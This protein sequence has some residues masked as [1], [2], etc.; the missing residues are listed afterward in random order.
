MIKHHKL[1]VKKT[2]S[3]VLLLCFKIL[4]YIPKQSHTQDKE[5]YGRGRGRGQQRTDYR[6]KDAQYS[7]Q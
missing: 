4:E 7:N 2:K 6:E 1:K 5:S 3:K